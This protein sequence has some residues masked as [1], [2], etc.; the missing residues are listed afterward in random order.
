MSRIKDE[1]A[2]INDLKISIFEAVVIHA[3]N[4]LNSHF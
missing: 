4:N 2:E 1:S 3:F